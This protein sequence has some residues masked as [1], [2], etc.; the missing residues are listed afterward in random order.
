MST[1]KCWLLGLWYPQEIKTPLKETLY[2]WFLLTLLKQ[3]YRC[4]WINIINCSNL[5]DYFPCYR[6]YYIKQKKKWNIDTKQVYEHPDNNN[7]ID[8]CFAL[9]EKWWDVIATSTF[10]LTGSRDDY[11]ISICLWMEY[12]NQPIRLTSLRW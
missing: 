2:Y 9:I 5:L 4:F 10:D 12:I 11:Y 3:L 7:I 8:G 6:N 1:K